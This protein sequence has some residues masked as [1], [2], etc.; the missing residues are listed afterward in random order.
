MPEI[1]QKQR[2]YG[3]IAALTAFFLWGLLPIYWKS[4]LV[5]NPFEILCHRIVWSLAFIAV[6][7]TFMKGWSAAI[8]PM[9][10]AK[11]LGILILS[12]LMIGTNWLLYI[13]AVNTNH[14]LETSLGY[15]INPLVN[16]LLGFLFFKERLKPLQLVA[17]GLAALG[18]VN[19]VISYGELPWISLVL[20]VSFGFYGLLRK[21]AAVE[22]LPGL[23]FETLVLAPIALGYII[24]LQMEGSSALFTVSPHIDFLLIGA[25]AATSIPL[26]GF[27][28]G[29]RRLQLT[30]LGLLQY[31][32]PTIAFCLGVFVYHEPFSVSHLITFALIWTGL[33]VYTADSLWTMRKHRRHTSS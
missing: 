3:F 15:Y 9:K 18:V 23:F 14:V 10:S 1:D 2:T 7:L 11:S 21:I 25:G 28:Y 24:K 8:A 17:I 32:A 13:W 26:I 31:L 16:V 5:V 12:S 19:S 22:S 33:A 30:T 20:A 29:A 27:A 4:L 6:V